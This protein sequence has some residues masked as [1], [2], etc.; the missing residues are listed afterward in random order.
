[1]Q[2]I[3]IILKTH[4]GY[5]GLSAYTVLSHTAS[6]SVDRT[7]VTPCLPPSSCHSIIISEPSKSLVQPRKHH[8]DTERNSNINANRIHITS[9]T[10]WNPHGHYHSQ[11]RHNIALNHG[12]R[13]S[14]ISMS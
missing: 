3:P 6:L 9:N 11:Q 8:P 14:H 12:D 13:H 5:G 7:T 1:V 4:T 2:N 10:T